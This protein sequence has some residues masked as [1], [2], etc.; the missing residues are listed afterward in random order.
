M[1]TNVSTRLT[2][3]PYKRINYSSGEIKDKIIKII[4]FSSREEIIFKELKSRK[5]K[6]VGREKIGR[7]RNKGALYLVSIHI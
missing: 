7:K 1:R 6:E 5:K 3:Y 2:N 4:Q